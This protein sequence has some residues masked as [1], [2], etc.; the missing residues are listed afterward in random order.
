MQLA[1]GKKALNEIIEKVFFSARFNGWDLSMTF[2]P[3]EMKMLFVLM[4]LSRLGL[5]AAKRNEI[6]GAF[7]CAVSD[8]KADPG[9]T[10]IRI[11]LG[12][13]LIS[14]LEHSLQPKHVLKGHE[15]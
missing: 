9:A 7:T 15:I 5:L 4:L 13:K 12:C 10:V 8:I 11:K 6:V 1:E 3:R 14:N 2:E